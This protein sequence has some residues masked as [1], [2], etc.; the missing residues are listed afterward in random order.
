MDPR[1][2]RLLRDA[3]ELGA[4]PL[5]R[6]TAA[7]SGDSLDVWHA[8]V[9]GAPNSAWAGCTLHL[10]LS[11]PAEYPSSP[12]SVTAADA[13]RAL[14]RLHPNLIRGAHN[15]LELCLSMLEP[16][17]QRESFSR[18]SER[19]KPSYTVR[20]VLQQLSSFLL[21]DEHVRPER[22]AFIAI[23]TACRAFTC[24]VCSH[25][26][27]PMPRQR[28]ITA[29][30]GVVSDAAIVVSEEVATR[31]SAWRVARRAT[32]ASTA[33]AATFT[34]T[35]T[36]ATTLTAAAAASTASASTAPATLTKPEEEQ[37]C[38]VE[39]R[40][41]PRSSDDGFETA[42]KPA[43]TQSKPLKNK[44]G[45]RAALAQMNMNGMNRFEPLDRAGRCSGC[46]VMSNFTRSQLERGVAMRCRRC[47][48]GGHAAV[49][50][51]RAPEAPKSKAAERNE[52]R[53][54]AKRKIV[55]GERLRPLVEAALSSSSSS[56][57]QLLELASLSSQQR[58]ELALRV[59][60]VTAVLLELHSSSAI[61]PLFEAPEMLRAKIQEA[62]DIF[63]RRQAGNSAPSAVLAFLPPPPP[64]S[65]V[66]STLR[67]APSIPSASLA[68][69]AAARA[70]DEAATQQRDWGSLGRARAAP[71][72]LL[73]RCLGALC[74]DDICAWLATCRA[75]AAVG[76]DAMLWRALTARSFGRR[77]NGGAPPVAVADGAAR[78]GG[79]RHAY[80]LCA[81]GLAN[82]PCCA[83]TR[84]RYDE[85]P[86]A[87]TLPIAGAMVTTTAP[88]QR[89]R[90]LL[91]YRM[92]HTTNPRT[93]EADY[94]KLDPE[95]VS[96]EAFAAHGYRMVDAD[97][98]MCADF[99]P[100][101]LDDAHGARALPQLL[102]LA[103]K[104][105]AV[106]QRPVRGGH[107]GGGPRRESVTPRGGG[108]GRSRAATG[109][110]YQAHDA[111]AASP[112]SEPE[113]ALRLL[114]KAMNT[115]V[116]LVADRG[117][118]A[119]D[120]ALEVYCQLQ[121]QCVCWHK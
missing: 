106:L 54:A 15:T 7:P 52:R 85:P 58:P 107:R 53:A 117:V 97:G 90:T 9:F 25:C 91:G 63:E 70:S 68:A 100:V 14:E 19:W 105:H 95:L 49:A 27:A 34:A 115:L 4:D 108:G 46:G 10:V 13:T 75:A 47:V 37:W 43:T 3:A 51:A 22:P 65:P 88:Q 113:L 71:Y 41:G 20:S 74:A 17:S 5:D 73:A 77:T 109:G 38:F 28:P 61:L 89:P 110:G 83:V 82:A 76:D 33:T 1:A 93:G 87:A 104:L 84:A 112:A 40:R 64:P 2:R 120:S 121:V 44:P 57:Q 69:A 86:A 26:D 79:W 99:L 29:V 48:S 101:W 66:P 42:A 23:R 111:T 45:Q 30:P 119:S 103:R 50:A 32:A 81:N 98:D 60:D 102:R 11:F 67:I 6:A 21:C 118:A 55:I 116:V 96:L 114:A 92:R 39:P 12:P 16:T 59:A 94:F 31:V 18:A 78:A 56:S 24:A 36:A 62:R 35:S 8:N 80:A 72:P